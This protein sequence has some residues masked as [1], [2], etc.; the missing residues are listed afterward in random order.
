MS[1]IGDAFNNLK[2]NLEITKTEEIA[3]ITRHTNIRDYVRTKW[4]LDDD[5]L[6]GSYRRRTKTKPLKDVDMFVVINPGGDQGYLR[7]EAPPKVLIELLKVLEDK[8]P[9]AYIDGMAIVIPFGSDDAVTSMEV[10]PAFARNG[11]GWFIPDPARNRWLATNPKT[12]HELSTAKNKESDDRFVPF[13]KMVK[14]ANRELGE[15][16]TPSFLLEVMAHEMVRP[17]FGK[18]SD[19]LVWFF[20]NAAARIDDVFSDPAGLGG[21]V[22]TM[23]AAQR[24]EAKAALLEAQ[25]IAERAVDLADAGQERSA[26]AE[27]RKL[28]R[29]RMPNA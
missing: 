19:E 18:Y 12:H 9:N 21:D 1:I 22:N 23:S 5:F 29:N 20:A 25:R 11:G 17:P 27:W 7:D 13:V 14:A 10:V 24:Q 8:W 6:T 16:V 28:F 26:V 2:S 3:A 4:D 15:K